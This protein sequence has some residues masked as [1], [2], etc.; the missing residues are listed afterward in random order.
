MSPISE[1]ARDSDVRAWSNSEMR[2]RS[3]HLR[4]R[5]NPRTARQSPEPKSKNGLYLDGLRINNIMNS[6]F[7]NRFDCIV[8][9]AGHAGSEASYI[10]A[11]GGLR[12]LLITITQYLR[13][14]TNKALSDDAY[15]LEELEKNNSVFSSLELKKAAA[16][17]IKTQLQNQSEWVEVSSSDKKERKKFERVQRIK[18]FL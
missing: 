17:Y 10:A 11:R 18:R 2:P 14:K 4:I 12:T 1:K 13:K 9:G 15:L 7:P 6:F 16:E 3:E 5:R 8:V